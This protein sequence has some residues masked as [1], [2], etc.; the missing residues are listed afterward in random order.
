VTGQGGRV[1]TYGYDAA[2]RLTSESTVDPVKGD[3]ARTYAYDLAGNIAQIVTPTE[4][5]NF[6]YNADDEILSDG[7]AT[8]EY[9]DAG[10]LTAILG[11][12]RAATFAYDGLGRLTTVVTTG[13][14]LGEHTV[15]YE[16]D[17]VGLIIRRIA[18]GE[19]TSLLWDRRGRT[20]HVLEELDDSGAVVARNT[21][22][23]HGVIARTTGGGTRYLHADRRGSVRGVSDASGALLSRIDYSAYGELVS[24]ALDATLGYGFTG[25]RHDS[26]TGLLYLRARHMAP[27]LGRF[28]T[29]DPADPSPSDP[30]SYHRYA[31]GGNN[32]V[33]F[34]DPEGRYVQYIVLAFQLAGYLASS[35]GTLYALM[36]AA[37]STVDGPGRL[38]LFTWFPDAGVAGTSVTGALLYGVTGGVEA[39]YWIPRYKKSHS[40]ASYHYRGGIVGSGI[41]A[42]AYGGVVWDVPSAGVWTGEAVTY[43]AK[44]PIALGFVT[45]VSALQAACNPDWVRG[46]GVTMTNIGVSGLVALNTSAFMA[47][48]T[49][50][51]VSIG[52]DPIPGTTS[53]DVNDPQGAITHQGYGLTSGPALTFPPSLLNLASFAFVWYEL[54]GAA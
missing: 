23:A 26:T 30:R 49:G 35:F 37:A 45:M 10:R 5:R 38:F 47:R 41:A 11:G 9:D 29:M 31:Y 13:S 1:T 34:V 14:A 19:A 46:V 54:I 52:W 42:G 51:D 8:Y 20:A 28:L 21:L 43:S 17:A 24:S 16:Y 32:P 50:L 25:E 27:A 36:G 33:M 3:D 39:L 48:V 15:E 6:T 53:D 12:P 18:D 22:G 44:V 7:T 40:L 2:D 4:T